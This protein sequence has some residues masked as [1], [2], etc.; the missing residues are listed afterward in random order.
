MGHGMRY[1]TWDEI[2]QL[3]ILGGQTDGDVCVFCWKKHGRRT[4][5]SKLPELLAFRNAR[6]YDSPVAKATLSPKAS[7]AKASDRS[8]W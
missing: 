8:V 2:L 3:F 6:T 1:G 5:R 7:M 4:W